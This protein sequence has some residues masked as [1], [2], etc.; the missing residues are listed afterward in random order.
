[1]KTAPR[2][3]TWDDVPAAVK[4]DLL[5]RRD[6]R[7]GATAIS[8]A[9]LG[10]R[11]YFRRTD[12]GWRNLS[13][14]RD[15]VTPDAIASDL[16][17]AQRA[18]AETQIERVKKAMEER[19]L[20]AGA[21]AATPSEIVKDVVAEVI[22]KVVREYVI[23]EARRIDSEVALGARPWHWNGRPQL[24][25]TAP[26][27]SLPDMDAGPSG[28]VLVVEGDRFYAPVRPLYPGRRVQLN[29]RDAMAPGEILRIS[30]D[31]FL[32]VLVEVRIL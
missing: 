10:E 29:F 27:V 22:E 15:A 4:N 19:G 31:A 21:S 26:E 5:S 3:V 32:D 13:V 11:W 20:A 2:F 30:Q 18:E 28:A 17:P 6:A 7:I 1:M 16:T 23:A 25:D 9:V 12:H 14:D 24:L 8:E